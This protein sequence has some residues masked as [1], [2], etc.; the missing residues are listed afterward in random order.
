MFYNFLFFNL[1]NCKVLPCPNLMLF[2]FL[3]WSFWLVDRNAVSPSQSVSYWAPRTMLDF[4]NSSKET[5]DVDYACAILTLFRRWSDSGCIIRY[6]IYILIY[7]SKI[8][9]SFISSIH[10]TLILCDLL[11]ILIFTPNLLFSY[12]LMCSKFSMSL[13]LTRPTIRMSPNLFTEHLHLVSLKS[14]IN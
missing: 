13:L 1:I 7:C 10:S 14:F 4:E 8:P 9:F 5:A 11:V 12:S 6:R 2:Y 3:L